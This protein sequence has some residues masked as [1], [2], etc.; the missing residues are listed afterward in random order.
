[1]YYIFSDSSIPSSAASTP[2]VPSAVPSG[3]MPYPQ[4]MQGMPLP[5][6]ATTVAPYPSYV[7]PPM[8]QGFNPY[9]TLPY[10]GSKCNKGQ[11]ILFHT[12]LK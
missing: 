3:S 7:P 5:Y 9:A 11:K 6:G 2:S 10:P 4:Q 1:M 12:K 8:P